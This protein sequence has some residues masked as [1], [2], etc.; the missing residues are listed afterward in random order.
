MPPNMR[1]DQPLGAGSGVSGNARD[2]LWENRSI[3]LH[4]TGTGMTSSREWILEDKQPGVVATISNPTSSPALFTPPVG[5]GGSYRVTLRYDGVSDPNLGAIYEQK[6]KSF[7]FRV[8]RDQA[9]AAIPNL[10]PLPAAF[11]AKEES[12]GISG[13]GEAGRGY[14]PLFDPIRAAVREL[15]TEPVVVDLLCGRQTTPLTGFDIVGSKVFDRSKYPSTFSCMFRARIF[16]SAG[17]TAQVRLF[18]FTDSIVVT[19]TLLS[20]AST[21]PT[22]V[23]ASLAVPADIPNASKEYEV[24][25]RIS[26]GAPGPGDAAF[27][28]SAQLILS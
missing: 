20:S 11:E 16:A 19:P 14:A 4:D 17:M 22:V 15:R 2:N 23:T 5:G 12:N 13:Q 9:G 3:E 1:I 25:L 7:V 8:T 18:N 28:L 21:T 27:I 10:F 26:A 24:Q 6:N